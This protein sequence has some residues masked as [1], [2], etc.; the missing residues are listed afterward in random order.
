MTI[1]VGSR[2]DQAALEQ[3]LPLMVCPECRAPLGRDEA[4]LVC[5]PADHRWEIRDG[6]PLLALSG[7][8]ET[9]DAGAQP[10]T[11]QEYQDQY[12][13]LEE[14]RAYNEAYKNIPTK[15]WSTRREYDL[16]DELLSSQGHCSLLLDLPC[17]GGRLSPQLEPNTDLLI[18]ADVGLGQLLYARETNTPQTKRV[19]MTASAFHIPFQAESVDG[20]VCCRLNHHLPTAAERERLVSELLRVSKRFVIMTFFDYHS[21]KNLIRRARQPLNRKPPKMTMTVDRVAELAAEQGGELIAAPPLSRI[22]S[23]H[24]YALIVKSAG[25]PGTETA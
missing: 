11:S 14:S 16:L 23:G 17:G 20:I 15:R 3:I 5:S 21:L 19:W 1:D 18:E 25:R 2:S 22:S 8:A 24:R 12:E 10:E 7:T 9:W 4:A 6:I 13:D